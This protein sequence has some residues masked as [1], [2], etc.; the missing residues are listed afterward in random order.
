MSRLEGL[1]AF[2][3]RPGTRLGTGYVVRE[4]L[5][6]GWEGEVYRVVEAG[7]GIERAAKLFYPARNLRGR[8]L[9][10]YARKLN[11]LKDV[12]VILQY[13]HKD[14]ARLGGRTVEFIVSEYV[15]GEVLEALLFRQPGR[16]FKTFEALL[17]LR[18]LADAVAPIHEA[19]EY[20]GDLHTENIM[21]RRKGV[22]FRIKLIDFFDLGRSSRE[23]IFTDT[24]DLVRILYDL[25]GGQPH[26]AR[27]APQVKQLVCGLRRDLIRRQFRTAVGLRSA[28]DTLEWD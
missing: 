16:R 19:G 4:L 2:D 17:I 6:K 10:Q 20:H 9:R 27:A 22:G 23:K 18:E 11:R 15:D 28:I 13:H 1:R 14:V 12:P 3:I 7:T 5:G 25:V 24:V 8:P 21:I 26:Y